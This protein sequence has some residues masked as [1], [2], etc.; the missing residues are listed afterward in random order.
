MEIKTRDFGMIDIDENEIITFEDPIFGFETIKKYVLLYDDSVGGQLMWLQSTEEQNI[1]F[2]L[3][4][5]VVLTYPY[6][7]ELRP[8]LIEMLQKKN[9]NEPVFRIIAVIREDL[10]KSTVNL[11]SPI[12]IDTQ[13]RRAAQIILEDD[14]SIREPLLTER[15]G[16]V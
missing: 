1:C 13:S 6:P 9:I 12:V 2:I 8:E 15:K 7:G 16:A 3:L 5:P 10:R 11:K 14:Y 4:D